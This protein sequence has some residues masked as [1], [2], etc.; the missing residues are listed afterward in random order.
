MSA[1]ESNKTLDTTID[2]DKITD[3][4]YKRYGD[5]TAKEWIA[6]GRKL[7]L[8]IE[9]LK[10]CRTKDQLLRFIFREKQDWFND[11]D[12]DNDFVYFYKFKHVKDEKEILVLNTSFDEPHDVSSYS[13]KPCQKRFFLNKDKLNEICASEDDNEIDLDSIAD[14]NISE[15]SNFTEENEVES[16]RQYQTRHKND[17]YKHST[18][19]RT[20]LKYTEDQD[21]N[22][23]LTCVES[24][25]QANNLHS[26]ES[27]ISI[28]TT[29]LTQSDVGDLAISLCDDDKK[30][31]VTFKSKLIAILGHSSDYYK[32]VFNTF[33]RN[34]MRLGLAL[35]TLTQYFRRGWGI[36]DRDLTLIEKEMI[37]DKFITSLE[38]PLRVMLKAESNS[39]TL[40]NILR[41]S[42]ELEVCFSQDNKQSSVVN[43]VDEPQNCSEILSSLQKSHEKMVELLQNHKPRERQAKKHN[44]EIFRKL[45]G[46]CSFYVKGI[47]C[48]K[49]S[50]RYKHDG[51]VTD[52]QR[53]I[54]KD[55]N[56]F[57]K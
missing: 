3:K 42:S 27:L 7:K 44:P 49:T 18:G 17:D 56:R 2:P 40:E 57:T 28:T 4:V 45:N 26:D 13:Y 10:R 32:N 48:P 51:P 20:K 55:L 24:Y 38:S 54:V 29:C 14:T 9:D 46:L 50:C 31:W 34:D 52:E 33:K 8:S 12:L 15:R 5:L 21:I 16:Y 30:D 35:S 25:C 47:D 39:L 19:F 22:R 6:V 1:G 53:L 11:L 41:R 36:N 43:S 37:K 23:F